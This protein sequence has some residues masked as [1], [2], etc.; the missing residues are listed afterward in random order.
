MG[1]SDY[2][3]TVVATS[4]ASTPAP[5]P[6]ESS[7]PATKQSLREDALAAAWLDVRRNVAAHAKDVADSTQIGYRRIESLP[8]AHTLPACTG[9]A[10]DL[11]ATGMGAACPFAR[12]GGAAA[13]QQMPLVFESDDPLVTADECEAVIEEAKAHLAAGRV[14][15]GFTLADTNHNLAVAD[16]PRTLGWLNDVALPRVAALAGTCFDEAAIGPPEDLLIYRA[17]VV[18]YDAAAG[19][20]HQEVRPA[21]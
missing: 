4:P 15:S 19:L 11:A 7:H 9:H 2:V 5:V 16:L 17:L 12:A 13:S 21:P 8:Q 3:G 20:T 18:G 10:V 1:S 6:E 14:G